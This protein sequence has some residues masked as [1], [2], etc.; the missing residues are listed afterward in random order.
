MVTPPLHV[1]TVHTP[2]FATYY[3]KPTFTGSGLAE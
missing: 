1:L 3:R 2:T